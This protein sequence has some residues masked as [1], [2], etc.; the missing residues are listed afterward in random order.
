MTQSMVCCEDMGRLCRCVS[1]EVLSRKQVVCQWSEFLQMQLTPPSGQNI[2]NPL[3]APAT[4]SVQG[5]GHGINT[6]KNNR[7]VTALRADVPGAGAAPSTVVPWGKQCAQDS[8]PTSHLFVG[9][10][11]GS[12]VPPGPTVSALTAVCLLDFPCQIS[13]LSAHFQLKLHP[14][15]A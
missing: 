14:V 9:L 2:P 7:S 15:K 8:L 12:T 4:V 13:L 5:F 3:S 11:V 1:C 6:P 10:P